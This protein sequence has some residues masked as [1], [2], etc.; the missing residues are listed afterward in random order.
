MISS[1]N[2]E[3]SGKSPKENEVDA[4][5]PNFNFQNFYSKIS[6][7]HDKE[8]YLGLK[9]KE[10]FFEL[11]Y[12]CYNEIKSVYMLNYNKRLAFT[13]QVEAFCLALK[14]KKFF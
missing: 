9:S 13:V 2:K 10:S 7:I 12:K 11:L 8:L 1:L 5:V 4:A 3:E 14:S 6:V